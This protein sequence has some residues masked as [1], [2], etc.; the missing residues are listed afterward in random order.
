MKEALG[1][2]KIILTQ[3]MFR[4]VSVDCKVLFVELNDEKQVIL[5]YVYQ[6]IYVGPP[7]E[8]VNVVLHLVQEYTE[9][10]T[11]PSF[12]AVLQREPLD[13]GDRKLPESFTNAETFIRRFSQPIW[14]IDIPNIIEVCLSLMGPPKDT[15][16]RGLLQ[17]VY[18]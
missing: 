1:E 10:T 7:S 13:I 14:R 15:T 6:I 8:P 4:N 2:A 3:P 17:A 16:E 5:P 12:F 18:A 9:S 11:V